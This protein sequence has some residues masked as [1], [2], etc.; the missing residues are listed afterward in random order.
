[1]LVV[2]PLLLVLFSGGK[3]VLFAVEVLIS[4]KLEEPPAALIEVVDKLVSLGE[5]V[6]LMLARRERVLDSGI[7]ERLSAPAEVVRRFAIPTAA[8]N[9]TPLPPTDLW[10]AVS[11]SEAAH[12][13]AKIV[14]L[15]QSH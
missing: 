13:I 1:M 5:P 15:L 3:R 12:I 6:P 8:G 14:F 10:Y 2:L 4:R 9:K 11:L 7:A